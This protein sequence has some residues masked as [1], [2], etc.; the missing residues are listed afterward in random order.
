MCKDVWH[1]LGLNY[2]SLMCNKRGVSEPILF[3]AELI[4]SVGFFFLM[5]QL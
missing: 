1:T 2:D 5:F 4:L 3:I